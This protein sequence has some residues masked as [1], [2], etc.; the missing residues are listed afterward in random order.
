MAVP[1][2]NLVQSRPATGGE[3][4]QFAPPDIL[5]TFLVFKHNIKSQ[6]FPTH[7]NISSLRPWFKATVVQLQQP[8]VKLIYK[9]NKLCK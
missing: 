5:K 3:T 1:F 7:E 2:S 4:G 6:S 8:K 9:V